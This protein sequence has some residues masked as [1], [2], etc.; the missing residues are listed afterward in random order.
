MSS[1]VNGSDLFELARDRDELAIADKKPLFS[2]NEAVS[3]ALRCLY[4]VDAPCIKACPTEID[5]PT[6]IRRIGTGDVSGSALTIFAQNT[7]GASCARICP[8][9]VLCEGSCVYT[10]WHR[11][12]I[13]IGRLQRFATETAALP[14]SA[15]PRTGAKRA[16]HVALIGAG[17][18]S[19]ACAAELVLHGHKATIFEKKKFGGGLNTSS[20]APY[21]LH[22]DDALAEVAWIAEM[23]VELHFGV[24]FGK[25]LR[26]EELLSEY[27]AVFIGVG[28]GEDSRL[29]IPGEDGKGVVG[30]VE[31]I[32]QMKLASSPKRALGA[33]VVIG[34]GNTAID[35][36]RECAQLGG[37]V[38]LVYRRGL[39][40]MSAYAH[41]VEAARKD[42]VTI[43]VDQTPRRF[44][45]DASGNLSG[46]AFAQT[47]APS[48]TIFPAQL[49]IVAIGQS[50][51]RG[52]A[53]Q[54]P[55]VEVNARGSIV[56]DP[57]TGV[58]GNDRVFAG[59]DSVNG[60][61]E[62]VNAVA[63][64]RDAARALI[65]RWAGATQLALAI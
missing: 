35:A 40:A 37:D 53:E 26:G 15:L 4:C 63:A 21:K 34:G 64:G 62:V 23:G 30:A 16:K 65:A 45:H 28:L 10:G 41:E 55:G 18:A 9:E 47:G 25:E 32:E 33:V 31:W 60:G 19:L 38:T 44:V 1:S 52:I 29:G 36:A 46:V 43:A 48:E 17:A 57:K 6:F 11:D 61:K 12:P 5:I 58:T 56:A 27:D 20:I 22:A 54:F 8:V 2:R 3:E 59:G 24:A 49:A 7:L 14:A 39:E 50:K 42:G 13:K 51:V